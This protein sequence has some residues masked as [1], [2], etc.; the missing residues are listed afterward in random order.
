MSTD[1]AAFAARED[2]APPDMERSRLRRHVLA[3]GLITIIVVA[4]ITVV[5]G[6]ASLRS[7][8][9]HGSPGWLTLGAGLK[10]LSGFSYVA[11]FRSVFCRRMS[12]RLSTEIGLAELGANAV[13]PTGGAG[14]LALGAWALHRAGMDGGRIARRSVAFFFLTSLPNVLGVV[15]LGAGLA[16]GAFAGRAGL[17]L[18]LLPALVAAVAVVATIA[19][20]RWAG[21]L[22]Q[23]LAARSAATSRIARAL[24][25]LSGGVAEALAL[26]R[27]RDPLL[28]FGL[29]GYLA[30]DVMILWSTFHAFGSVPPLAIIWIGYL[31][32]ELG[33]L[34]PVPGGIGG[35]DVGLV[36]TLVLYHVPLTAAT[37][38]VLAYRALA[39][40]IPAALGSVTFAL[41]RRSLARE[42]FAI[43]SCE[44]GGQVEVIGR[45]TV[46]LTA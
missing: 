32:G 9:A 34:I 18:T 28:L 23:R 26:L 17:G 3:L 14:G 24:R 27:A 1:I 31:I 16:V 39:L 38:A 4:L 46:R 25:T 43:S 37:A 2:L 30:F 11:V 8:F 6:L 41:L 10:V 36:G 35:V 20:G 7:R 40:L 42:A 5:P 22:E 15:I 12:W 21:T 29:A 19:G 33:G 45:G 13:I 44:P